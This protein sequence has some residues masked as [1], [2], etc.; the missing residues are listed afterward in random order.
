MRDKSE[1]LAS[2]FKNPSR[3]E[4]LE[5]LLYAKKQILFA[6]DYDGT[7]G[8]SKRTLGK[9]PRDTQLFPGIHESMQMLLDN[10]IDVAIISGR[11]GAKIASLADLDDIEVFGTYGLELFKD[12][13]SHIDNRLVPHAQTI[14]RVLLDIRA[15]FFNASG[16]NHDLPEKFEF[17]EK[18][19]G[20]MIVVEQKGITKD[21]PLGISHV[22]HFN[23]IDQQYRQ[24]YI[25]FLRDLYEKALKQFGVQDTRICDFHEDSQMDGYFHS[26]SLTPDF[27]HSKAEILAGL[28]KDF[29][30]KHGTNSLID[31]HKRYDGI[32]YLGDSD[33]DLGTFQFL[34]RA[35]Q[36]SQGSFL[37][38]SIGIQSEFEG[39]QSREAVDVLLPNVEACARFIADLSDF[40]SQ[41]MSSRP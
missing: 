17:A 3:L 14:S 24:S 35:E 20:G 30:N 7:L 28:A 8:I 26:V 32:I 6:S 23:L 15:N 33:Q 21:F 4:D 16:I 13:T 36:E 37:G 31:K 5:K 25:E 1:V 34:K 39:K 19:P 29:D 22:Y 38:F 41:E 11:A 9:D 40:V 12:E 27:M 10:E 18:I 2:Y